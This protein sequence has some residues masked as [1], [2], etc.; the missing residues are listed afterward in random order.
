M[1]RRPKH[2]V[3]VFACLAS[4]LGT[5]P[6]SAGV[7][8]TS[9]EARELAERYAP[10]VV[11]KAQDGPCDTDGEAFAPMSVDA[12]LDND[13]VTLRQAGEGDPV[14]VRGPAA[15]DLHG[16]G[17]GFFLDFN[18]LA[19]DPG[20]VYEQDFDSYTDGA[21]SVVYAH[22]VQQADA[23][24]RLAVQYWFYWYYNDW[25]NTHESDWEFI[26]VL[27]DASTI[28]EALD[29]E[30]VA[31]G[32]AQHEGGERAG[33]GD[34]KFER[35]GTHPVVYPSAGSHA[36]YFSSSTFLGRRGTEGFGCDTTLGPSVTTR[37]D[38]VALPD[39]AEAD[40]HFA[41]LGFTGRWGERQSGPFNGPTGPNTKFQWDRP[42]DW[43]NELRAASVAIPGSDEGSATILD[44]FCNVVDFGSNQLRKLQSSPTQTIVTLGA[45][46]LA[47][48]AMVRRTGWSSVP[49]VPLRRRRRIGQMVRGAFGAYRTSP[50]AM[51]GTALAY[52]PAAA[53]VGVVAATA[54]F[55]TGQAMAGFLT[56]IMLVIASSLIA[57]FW[58]LASHDHDRAFV[59]T[60]RLLRARLPALVPTLL[61]AVVIVVVLGLTV[62]GLPWAIR[63]AIRYQ[64]VVPVV[65][66]E[67]LQGAA[68]LA[69]ST[70]LVKGRWW[71]TALTVLLFAGLAFLINSGLQ[72]GLLILF[73]GAPLWA[74]LAISFAV[75][76]LVVP[77]VATPSVL[78]YGDAAAVHRERTGSAPNQPLEPS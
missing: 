66:T 16:R 75:L 3:F 25:N 14:V 1:S 55:T 73:S 23:P 57:G 54:G 59:G 48:R 39:A 37:P 11:L 46:G 22:V 40:S 30:P 65:V 38:I 58:H 74:Y 33:W 63:Q 36:S 51:A 64:F 13:D 32:Y 27:F 72:L 34:S 31:V 35:E 24:D 5:I 17:E 77:L 41:W 42:I 78:L 68:A 29:S 2:W 49:A 70:E 76:G 71:R 4:L 61:R 53:L 62:V 7:D 28:A 15:A 6:A 12:V 52:I 44:T 56:T 8:A 50:G 9:D 20:C 26:Q 43:H 67:D 10:I 18:G 45:V 21:N 47:V 60:L 69:R 19:L